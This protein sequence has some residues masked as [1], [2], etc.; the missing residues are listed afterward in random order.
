VLIIISSR[1]FYYLDLLPTIYLKLLILYLYQ[2]LGQIAKS[3]KEKHTA[4][5]KSQRI[6]VY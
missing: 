5:V 6:I 3:G 1:K 4:L 2:F